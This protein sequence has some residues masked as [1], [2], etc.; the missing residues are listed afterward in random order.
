MQAFFIGCCCWV[1]FNKIEFYPSNNFMSKT[2]RHEQALLE[3]FAFLDRNFRFIAEYHLND[4]RKIYLGDRER[5]KCRFCKREN[6]DVT[7]R[8]IAH[9]IPEFT[10]NK[11]LFAAYECDECNSKFSR[12][13]E[14]H[15]ANYMNMWHTFSQV[16]G[17]RG[18]PSFKTNQ[19][20]S[21][22]DLEE[23]A[24][25]IE[26][27]EGDSIAEFQETEKTITIKAKRAS[28]I[29]IAVYK[30]LTKMALTIMPEEH[31]EDFQL[32]LDWINEEDH[33]TSPIS[34]PSLKV[35]FSLASGAH[36]YPFTTIALLNRKE[37]APDNVPHMV[38]LL[39]YGNF[40][41]QIWLP[42]SRKDASLADKNVTMM[43]IPTPVDMA[44]PGGLRYIQ[45]ELSGKEL[46]RGEEETIVLTFDSMIERPVDSTY[47]R[48]AESEKHD[49]P[50]E[51]D[52]KKAENN[53]KGEK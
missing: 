45:L 16:R 41:F 34:F 23:D 47:V 32:T 27:H 5:R 18:V 8:N 38:A 7:F 2:Q 43:Y 3:R 42:L 46:V 35:L 49:K 12:T 28:Y 15:M 33:K 4:D 53:T 36:P 31:L 44:D 48:S 29:P 52:A 37:D 17:K 26:N 40:A 19:K 20:K 1:L 51:V 25:Y 11:T 24:V 21:R 39:A 9:A 13:L 22:V 50:N 30:C 6:P 14:S 10:G